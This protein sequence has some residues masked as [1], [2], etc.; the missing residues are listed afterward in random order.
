MAA[1][2]LVRGILRGEVPKDVV[3]NNI[4]IKLKIYIYIV[5]I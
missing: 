3:I 5:I 1:I 4:L 2:T